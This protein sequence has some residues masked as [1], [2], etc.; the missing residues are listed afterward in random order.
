MDGAYTG[1]GVKINSG[2]LDGLDI[3]TAKALAID[4]LEEQ[5]I[6][7]SKVNYRLR[8]WLISR[9]RFWGCPIPAVY[10]DVHGVVPVPEDQLP[11]VAPDDVEF[12]PTGQSPL[13]YHEG[14]L[15]TTCPIDGGPARRE[16]DTMDTFVDSAWYFLRFCDPWNTERPFDPAATEHFMPVDQYIGGIEHAILHLLYARFYTRALIDVGLAPGLPREPFKRYLAQGM[17]RMDGTKMSKSKGN[18][19]AP[20]HYYET[21]GADGLRL[22]HLFVGPPFDDMDWSEQTEQIIEGC[23]RF[24][25]RLWRTCTSTPR[26]RTGAQSEADHAVRQAVHRT[27]A[28]VTR[29]IDRWSY[30][31]AVAHSMELLNLLQQYGRGGSGNDGGNGNDGDGPQADVWNEGLDVLLSLLA[32]LTPHVTA[33]LWE[34]RHPGEPSIHLQRWPDYDPELVRQDTVTMVVQV[35]G[36]VRDRIDVDA[37]ISEADAEVAALASAKVTEALAGATPKRVVSR[38]PRLVNLVV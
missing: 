20:E 22:F 27:I 4:W 14:F 5:G 21:V 3:T 24:L 31:T 9:Q 1:E 11:I 26:L 8:D 2:F 33:E 17:I 12:L 16:T 38:P 19:I 37:G 29:D 6:G 13:A 32:P 28:D 15:H 36:K 23:G 7:E 10:C 35:N 18:L 30:N 25:D 34:H